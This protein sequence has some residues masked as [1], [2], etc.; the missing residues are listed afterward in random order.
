MSNLSGATTAVF[1]VSLSAA[2]EVPV[3]VAWKTKDG[4]AKAGT[5][6]EAASGSVTFEPG[7]TTQQIQVAVYG[8][9]E[10]DTE[11]RTFGI[12]LYPPENAI[13]DQTLTEVDILVT[14]ESGTAVTSLVVATG[15]RGLKGDPGLSS[16]ELAKLQ[17]YEG[18][19]EEY[20][21]NET[22]AG[23]SA[24]K[25][26]ASANK[27]EQEANR[28]EDAA[29]RAE[30]VID[31]EG[32]YN[33]IA[34]GLANTADGKFFRV[35]QGN[36][37]SPA[38]FYY[39]NNA[40]VAKFVAVLDNHNNILKFVVDSLN[41]LYRFDVAHC[42]TTPAAQAGNVS[43]SWFIF[44]DVFS[45]GIISKLELYL[46][47]AGKVY[48]STFSKSGNTFTR[49]RTTL[50]SAGSGL[51]SLM[52][53]LFTDSGDYLGIHTEGGLNYNPAVPIVGNV[54]R[55]ASA[56]PNGDTTLNTTGATGVYAYTFQARITAIKGNPLAIA[57]DALNTQLIGIASR[58]DNLPSFSRAGDG[59]RMFMLNAPVK[60][61][62]VVTGVTWL[63]NNPG[64]SS[65]TV[66][67]MAYRL[68]GGT[69]TLIDSQV[70][71]T[72]PADGNVN[73]LPLYLNVK[74]GDFLVFSAP[75]C[76]DSLENFGVSFADTAYS[77]YSPTDSAIPTSIPAASFAAQTG[78]VLCA[79]FVVSYLVGNAE[80]DKSVKNA[81]ISRLLRNTDGVYLSAVRPIILDAEGVNGTA[82][83][84]YVPR[85]MNYSAM[86]EQRSITLNNSLAVDSI[87]GPYTKITFNSMDFRDARTNYR[88]VYIDLST[89]TLKVIN[90]VSG[91]PAVNILP[92]ME[93]YG[94]LDAM[95]FRVFGG[96]SVIQAQRPK[97]SDALADLYDAITNP[98]RNSHIGLIGD[99]ITWGVGAT[100]I[101]SI[102]PRSHQLS[103]A[104]NNFTSKTWANLFRKWTAE[105]AC[106]AKN[107]VDTQSTGLSTYYN[108]VN[109]EVQDAWKDFVPSDTASGLLT[110]T[111]AE[112]L[113]TFGAN[114]AIDILAGRSVSFQFSGT[115]ISLVYA[116]LQNLNASIY[117]DG[118]LNTTVV[119]DGAATPAFGTRLDISGLTDSTHT[120]RIEC[121][122]S[123]GSPFRLQYLIRNKSHS[124][125]NS[126]LIG[127]NTAEWLP[128]GSLLVPS[129]LPVNVTHIIIQLGTND[130][131]MAA[132]P[133][134]MAG[135]QG[136]FV[137]LNSIVNSLRSSYP[138]VRIILIAPPY[139]PTDSAYGSSDEIA[140][141]VRRAAR[142]LECGFI[143]QY[144]A[145]L[146]VEMQGE[147]WLS[148]G[149]HPNDYGYRVMF[150]NLQNSLLMSGIK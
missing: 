29:D 120:M 91:I 35:P 39:Q 23:I 34:T 26:E 71:N 123:A 80:Q 136:T 111:K 90:G 48:V 150:R 44:P 9:A 19:L 143:D 27:S 4:T 102:D 104:R 28:A 30:S 119:T 86:A 47:A 128:G 55:F 53:E 77:I 61:D 78:S 121:G 105:L 107:A 82:N 72:T 31:V 89:N 135:A 106:H 18:T 54:Y 6:Y 66:R 97:N 112:T 14:D 43:E 145:T 73:V 40:G 16:Y 2:L 130:R 108:Q 87:R 113:R 134:Y 79:R 131:G 125:M 110:Q 65:Q 118:V 74:A 41:S 3:T 81:M 67:A 52:P 115:A 15:P 59:N 138:G 132:G 1:I 36:S 17:G 22:A 100:G 95:N 33:D 84:I 25:A 8:R 117:I 144:S 51:N 139:A 109:I 98:L 46:A 32:T 5:D 11:T 70:V 85:V 99:S 140:R 124:V 142:V 116:T 126:G 38:F 92:V 75:V 96:L 146:E 129:A 21:Q 137:N 147:S 68:S 148:D 10:G 76:F 83:C 133:S 20:I 63:A 50:L 103:D 13:L 88:L 57:T 101:A 49:K 62:G 7:E 60:Y 37:N 93:I 122:I 127:T 149:L 69:Y 58:F 56:N 42:K 12:E 141:A 45:E 64:G 94:R 24:D 114:H